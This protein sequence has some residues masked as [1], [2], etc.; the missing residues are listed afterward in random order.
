MSR[1]GIGNRDV[2]G[3][4]AV[5]EDGTRETAGMGRTMHSVFWRV[6]MIPSIEAVEHF[7]DHLAEIEHCQPCILVMYMKNTSRCVALQ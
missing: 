3:C 2:V 6:C 1:Y 7:P 5:V 4:V